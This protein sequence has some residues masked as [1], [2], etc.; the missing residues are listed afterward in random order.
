M[1]SNQTNW[2]LV[3]HSRQET[4]SPLERELGVRLEEVMTEI[5]LISVDFLTE[6]P[7][8][9]PNQNG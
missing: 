9:E 1:Y 4:A 3:A 6:E 2:Q 5:Q 8:N 7:T